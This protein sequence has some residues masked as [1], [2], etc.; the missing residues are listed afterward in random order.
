MGGSWSLDDVGRAMRAV[1]PHAIE[2]LNQPPSLSK[3]SREEPTMAAGDVYTTMRR[4]NPSD[5]DY[6][7]V[8]AV[9]LR[10]E[11]DAALDEIASLRDD[12]TGLIA[13]CRSTDPLALPN[14]IIAYD[15]R[16]H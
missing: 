11:I 2:L 3:L 16:S 5:A 12:L 15:R 10:V 9:M 1:Q 13:A 7:A 14:W 6:S 8:R 4:F